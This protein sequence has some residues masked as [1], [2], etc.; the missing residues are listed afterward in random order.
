MVCNIRKT[1]RGDDSKQML[2]EA[3]EKIKAGCIK[4]FI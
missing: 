3:I 1:N 4:I 2:E